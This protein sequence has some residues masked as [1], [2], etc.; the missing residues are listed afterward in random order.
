MV[1]PA[2]RPASVLP[3]GQP[4]SEPGR[5]PQ[6]EPGAAP[7]GA[8]G[9]VVTVLAAVAAVVWTV[10]A[11]DSGARAVWEPV[12]RSTVPGSQPLG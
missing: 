11:G 10:R 7:P 12:V 8:A 4:Q 5:R 6:P 1:G 9:V 3:G 2:R